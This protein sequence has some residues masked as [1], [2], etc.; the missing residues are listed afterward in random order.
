MRQAYS[1]TVRCYLNGADTTKLKLWLRSPDDA[2]AAMRRYVPLHERNALRLISCELCADQL[3]P[4]ERPTF[5]HDY[6]VQS[7]SGDDVI[8]PSFMDAQ[9]QFSRLCRDDAD[10]IVIWWRRVFDGTS[11]MPISEN[12]VDERRS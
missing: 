3:R 9:R 12:V 2:L 6:H 8:T 11:D 5:T 1:V 7:T 4:S 10:A